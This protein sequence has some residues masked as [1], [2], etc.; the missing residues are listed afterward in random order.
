MD[1]G[2][3]GA[4]GRP[5]A[6]WRAREAI[7]GVVFLIDVLTDSA[8]PWAVAGRYHWVFEFPAPVDPLIPCRGRPS[9]R[10]PP[11]AAAGR[12]TGLV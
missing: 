2:R 5:R 6:A 8:S 7:I 12:L 11:A 3:P 9:L 1:D 4:F 10:V